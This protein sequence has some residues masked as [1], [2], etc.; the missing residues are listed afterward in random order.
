MNLPM[1]R[2]L[3]ATAV[4]AMSAAACK[5]TGVTT[6]TIDVPD[7]TAVFDVASDADG[8]LV[9][10]R[11]DGIWLY[12]NGRFEAQLRHEPATPLVA[13]ST[14]PD[15]FWVYQPS[16]AGT[17]ND[18]QRI[19]VT[20]S[21]QVPVDGGHVDLRDWE[22]INDFAVGDGERIYVAGIYEDGEPALG[23][24]RLSTTN[25]GCG[26]FTI[27]K[28]RSDSGEFMDEP[29]AIA[30]DRSTD[31]VYVAE[32]HGLGSR[33]MEYTA[34]LGLTS[35]QARSGPLV[36]SIAADGALVATFEFMSGDGVK[37][38]EYLKLFNVGGN[39][40][41]ESDSKKVLGQHFVT[42]YA[43]GDGCGDMWAVRLE[44]GNMIFDRHEVCSPAAQ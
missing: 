9:V 35:E 15:H 7:R 5:F 10:S 22:K 33:L 14:E 41:A 29:T 19:H 16:R 44:S 36:S 13:D 6:F 30:V 17:A 2:A 4:L 8:R 40:F 25:G 12:R 34:S 23:T 37:K 39:A 3:C 31:K 24:C 32:T 28:R 38:A 21:G 11:N 43:T 18:L 27:Q 42:G 1:K 20:R 26:A